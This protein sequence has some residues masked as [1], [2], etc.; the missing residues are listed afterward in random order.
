MR[1]IEADRHPRQILAADS[2]RRKITILQILAHRGIPNVRR[3]RDA[4]IKVS[5]FPCG[6]MKCLP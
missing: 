3:E 5:T 2:E 1:K 4:Q 6:R